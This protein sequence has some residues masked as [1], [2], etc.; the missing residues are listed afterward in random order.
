MDEVDTLGAFQDFAKE[1]RRGA[2]PQL[3]AKVL[4]A[5][6][7][8][9]WYPRTL[10]VEAVIAAEDRTLLP[11]LRRLAER[12][13]DQTALAALAEAIG[14]LGD[15]GDESLLRNVWRRGDEPTRGFV[16]GSMSRLIGPA[17]VRELMA[18]ERSERVRAAGL[19]TFLLRGTEAD[20]A[21]LRDGLAAMTDDN[22]EV[23]MEGLRWE[24]EASESDGVAP[25]DVRRRVHAIA[26]SLLASQRQDAV[27]ALLTSAQ[28]NPP[29]D[30]PPAV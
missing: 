15:A 16:L 10:A 6:D 23:A 27:R 29:I 13:P 20:L 3:R 1:P 19:P 5:L 4:A 30:P 21:D 7:G 26:G 22:F 8:P 12:E 17:V 18:E 9:D 2:W 24:V 25:E 11:T 28:S 14:E